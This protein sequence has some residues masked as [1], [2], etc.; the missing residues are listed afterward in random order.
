MTKVQHTVTIDR[1]V[2]E[3]WD[4]VLTTRN[5]P[6]WITNVVDVG[7]GSDQPIE[8]GLEIEETY[9]FLGK[10]LPMTMKVTEHEPHRRS[11]IEFTSGPLPGRGSYDFEP[12]GGGT[13]F[14]MSL[15]TDAHG[16]FKLAEPVFARMARRDA[17]ASL[18]NLKDILESDTS[19][20][21]F[22]THGP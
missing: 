19:R 22:R 21:D 2:E 5:D 4:Y 3:V 6:V 11:A 15:E 17:V 20:N 9:T 7:R 14:T 1:P 13:R 10:R 8:V 16:F 18:E 12:A